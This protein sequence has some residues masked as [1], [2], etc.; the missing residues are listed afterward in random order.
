MNLTDLANSVFGNNETPIEP[1]CD[2]CDEPY[3]VINGNSQLCDECDAWQQRADRLD[4][5]GRELA[6]QLVPASEVG[7]DAWECPG[8]GCEPGDGYT[9]SCEHPDGCGFFT[10]I[11]PVTVDA[12]A[13]VAAY[14]PTVRDSVL[15]TI[16][17][18]YQDHASDASKD[19]CAEGLAELLPAFRLPKVPTVW[20]R[21]DAKREAMLA[22][23]STAEEREA[24]GRGFHNA[25]ADGC[26]YGWFLS[27]MAAALI[28]SGCASDLPWLAGYD[29]ATKGTA[30][31]GDGLR[32]VT[33]MEVAA[34][35][36]GAVAVLPSTV[37]RWPGTA[38]DL[39]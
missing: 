25:L 8:C 17:F 27:P 5:Q 29:Y 11:A 18:I 23:E 22:G 21:A 36:G 14:E 7:S 13:Q 30:S 12:P 35:T 16:T 6:T 4:A 2:R 32:M 31:A 1:T 10:A 9:E 37:D 28:Y 3:T 20:E 19:R 15:S 38:L 39:G 34:F 26:E 24:F 33:L